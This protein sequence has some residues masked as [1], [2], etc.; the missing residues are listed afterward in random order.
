MQL[1]FDQMGPSDMI[2]NIFTCPAPLIIVKSR[3][4]YLTF[5]PTTT[6]V[7]SAH[8]VHANKSLKYL[9]WV[10]VKFMKFIESIVS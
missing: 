5:H 6:F 9:H 10:Y 3:I 2:I 7:S 1:S 4:S 8:G